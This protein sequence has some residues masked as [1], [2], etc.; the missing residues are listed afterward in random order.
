MNAERFNNT[1]FSQWINSRNGRIF[2]LLAGILF[3]ILG[4]FYHKYPLGIV[5]LVWSFFPL[6]AGGFDV[7]YISGVLGGPFKGA[8]IRAL[9]KHTHSL[10]QS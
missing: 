5:S 10:P 8:K 3:L 1:E 9:Q 7:C 6:S 2:R 4:I